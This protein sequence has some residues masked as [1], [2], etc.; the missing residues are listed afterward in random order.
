MLILTG[1]PCFSLCLDGIS[2]LF[3][4]NMSLFTELKVEAGWFMLCSLNR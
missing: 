4:H 1:E 3:L 2:A